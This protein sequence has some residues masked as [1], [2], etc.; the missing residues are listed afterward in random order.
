MSEFVKFVLVFLQEMFIVSSIEGHGRAVIAGWQ[1][2]GLAV[3]LNGWF[4]VCQPCFKINAGT[5][6]MLLKQSVRVQIRR[7]INCSIYVE[8]GVFWTCYC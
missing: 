6:F 1:L 2:D 3:L 4:V 8:N 7:S 5:M